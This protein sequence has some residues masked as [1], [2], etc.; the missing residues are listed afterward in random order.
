MRL[1]SGFDLFQA[2]VESLDLGKRRVR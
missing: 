1:N 2:M